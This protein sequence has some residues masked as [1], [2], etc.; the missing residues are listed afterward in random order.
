[1][2]KH[3]PNHFIKL[4]TNSTHSQVFN[5]R[6]KKQGENCERRYGTPPD[7][8]ALSTGSATYRTKP[9]RKFRYR[10]YNVINFKTS[11]VY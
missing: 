2:I 9:S 3:Q 8:I 11:L 7:Q 6:F 10:T 1:M 5:V 4:S